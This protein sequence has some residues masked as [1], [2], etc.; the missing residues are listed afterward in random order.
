MEK[1]SR[2]QIQLV[3]V[4][5]AQA[6]RQAEFLQVPKKRMVATTVRDTIGYLSQTCK[7][8]FKRRFEKRP[9]WVIVIIV[10]IDLQGIRR[11]R[12]RPET[13]KGRT[14]NPPLK[15]TQPFPYIIGNSNGRSCLLY[16]FFAMQPCKYTKKLTRLERK[17]TS[18]ITLRNIHFYSNN[19]ILQHN[20]DIENADRVNITSEY[21]KNDD[22]NAYILF[23]EEYVGIHTLR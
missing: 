10:G 23:V 14:N 12:S 2:W 20:R 21:Q 19:S 9:R 1:F 6:V 18:I 4:A 16:F 15:S 5:L 17:I 7:G 22:Q 8:I 13:T 11:R 3:L